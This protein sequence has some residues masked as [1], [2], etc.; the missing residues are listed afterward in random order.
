MDDASFSSSVTCVM[1]DPGRMDLSQFEAFDWC[2]VRSILQ[3]TRAADFS[4]ELIT[5]E[6]SLE[7]GAVVSSGHTH[8]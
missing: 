6:M 7:L 2:D 8:A 1:T 3:Q 5:Q 4:G